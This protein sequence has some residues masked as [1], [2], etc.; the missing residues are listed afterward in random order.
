MLHSVE[1]ATALE[2]MED[3]DDQPDRERLD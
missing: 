2:K 3:S 1:Q